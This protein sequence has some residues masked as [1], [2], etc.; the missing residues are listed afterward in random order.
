METWFDNKLGIR[1][2]LPQAQNNTAHLSHTCVFRYILKTRFCVAGTVFSCICARCSFACETGKSWGKGRGWIRNACQLHQCI[3]EILSGTE[4]G[5]DA[6]DQREKPAT[7]KCSDSSEAV[8]IHLNKM[9]RFTVWQSRFSLTRFIQKSKHIIKSTRWADCL[10][11]GGK[12][13][14][15]DAYR[16]NLSVKSKMSKSSSHF[17]CQERR[18]LTCLGV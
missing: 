7:S 2:T 6:H 10:T 1:W 18:K 12:K 9:S 8:G 4:M 15:S 16:S 5:K 14:A 17:Y 11:G 13:T 3:S